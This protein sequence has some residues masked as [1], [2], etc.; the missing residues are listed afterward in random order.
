MKNGRVHIESNDIMLHVDSTFPG[1]KLLPVEAT[2]KRWTEESLEH[3][4]SLHMDI[5]TITMNNL[6][7]QIQR[8]IGKMKAGKLTSELRKKRAGRALLQLHVFA[9]YM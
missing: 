7:P 9:H 3:E 6:P 2:A 5:R 8:A 1:P 4:D